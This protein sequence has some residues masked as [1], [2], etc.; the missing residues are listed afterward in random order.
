MF[1]VSIIGIGNT[2]GRVALGF[3]SSLPGVDALLINNVFITV[4]GL[5]TMFSGL[6]LTKEYQFFYAAAFGLSVC[7]FCTSVQHSH[8]DAS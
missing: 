2:I 4:S 1:L 8:S 5:L 7:K 6:S 3:I